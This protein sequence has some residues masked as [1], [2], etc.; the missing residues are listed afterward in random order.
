VV[1]AGRGVAGKKLL[2]AKLNFT[3]LN[4]EGQ[5]L[6]ETHVFSRAGEESCFRPELVGR[7]FCKRV[8][9]DALWVLRDKVDNFVS[10]N[11]HSDQDFLLCRVAFR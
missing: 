1:S 10:V 11:L 3:P 8:S 2:T 6:G 9:Q 7:D 4:E 5:Q